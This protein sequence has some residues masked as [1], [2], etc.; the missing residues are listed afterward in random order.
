MFF[1]LFTN[2]IRYGL[3]FSP[4]RMS[5]L[6]STKCVAKLYLKICGVTCCWI[7]KSLSKD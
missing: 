5:V 6:F 4:S 3:Y 2:H 1:Y 7:E